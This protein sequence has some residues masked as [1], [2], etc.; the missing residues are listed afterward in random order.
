M[1]SNGEK[2]VKSG[3]TIPHNEVKDGY[4]MWSGRKTREEDGSA[5][6]GEFIAGWWGEY[7]DVWSTEDPIQSLIVV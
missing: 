2:R 1:L 7:V 6:I 5:N 4:S 3:E